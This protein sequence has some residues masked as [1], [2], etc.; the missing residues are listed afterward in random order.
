MVVNYILP[1]TDMKIKTHGEFNQEEGVTQYE[2]NINDHGE[3]ML[4]ALVNTIDM[5]GNKDFTADMFNYSSLK[6]MYK[7]EGAFTEIREFVIEPEDS[8]KSINEAGKK[9]A[10]QFSPDGGY[11]AVLARKENV[12]KIYKINEEDE[13]LGMFFD[14]LSKKPPHL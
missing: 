3:S 7:K 11:L 9:L 10:I 2:D 4:D 6:L 12:L 14:D 13:D 1:D 5:Q 8:L